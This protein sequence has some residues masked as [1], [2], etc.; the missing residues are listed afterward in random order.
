MRARNM[1]KVCSYMQSWHEKRWRSSL[2]HLCKTYD[3]CR[4]DAIPQSMPNTSSFRSSKHLRFKSYNNFDFWGGIS[5]E[6][7]L[8]RTSWAV[9]VYLVLMVCMWRHGGHVGGQEHSIFMQPLWTNFLLF[10]PPTWRRCKPPIAQA[11]LTWEG[12]DTPLLTV[13]HETCPIL[14]YIGCTRDQI[15]RSPLGLLDMAPDKTAKRLSLKDM[16]RQKLLSSS[17]N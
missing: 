8:T 15:V 6:L 3:K 2:V 9:Y 4:S 1:K 16:F 14:V 12:N 17:V 11:L 10:C 7:Y 13:S 5:A